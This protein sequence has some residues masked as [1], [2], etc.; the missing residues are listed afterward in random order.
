MKKWEK[1]PP[2][3]IALFDDIFPGPPA[4]RRQMFGYPAGFVNGN[5]FFSLFENDM[6]L[7]LPEDERAK[8]I[9]SGKAK[10]FEPMAGR[11][12][13]EYV[14]VSGPLEKPRKELAALAALCFAHAKSIR[15]KSASSRSKKAP[16]KTKASKSAKRGKS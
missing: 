15:P 11:P 13:R 14:A 7:R 16:G 1:S 2:E 4:E 8:L 3:L 6:V 5:L 9:S 12:M 10:Q